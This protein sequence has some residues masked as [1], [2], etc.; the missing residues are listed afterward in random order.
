MWLAWACGGLPVHELP[1][2]TVK[3]FILAGQSNMQGQGVVDLDHPQYYNG[4]KGTLVWSMEHSASK[5][6]MHH[7]RDSAQQWV[8]RKDVVVRSQTEHGLKTGGLTIGFSGYDGMHHIGPE[9]QF[10]HRVGD[11]FEDPVLLI[12]TCWGGKSLYQDFRPPS[13]EGETGKSYLKMLE[14]I[15]DALGNIKTD[16]P[17]LETQSYELAGFVWMQGWN[18]MINE[19]ARQQYAANLVLLAHD[20]R[21]DLQAPDLPIVVGELGNT[22][23]APAGSSMQLFRE[24]QAEG[25]SR[26]KNARFVETRHFARPAELSPNVGHAHHWFGNAESYF[27]VGDQLGKSMVELIST[28]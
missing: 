1:A 20:L 26:I 16:F 7:L 18:D 11:H 10:G 8:V 17:Q 4:G 5:D 15:R 14:E 3:V 28:K 13:A 27:F 9:L 6:R 19:Q 23:P 25:T 24:A 22:G 2:Q 12:K 21:R